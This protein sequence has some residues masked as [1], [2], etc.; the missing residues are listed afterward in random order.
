MKFILILCLVGFGLQ[1]NAQSHRITGRLM[2]QENRPVSYAGVYLFS[3]A[4]SLHKNAVQSD[5]A[6]YFQIT[7]GLKGQYLVKVRYIGYQ[8][9]TS[10]VFEL[11][12]PGSVFSM[13]NIQLKEDSHSLQTVQ[14]SGARPMIEQRMDKMVMNVE[15]SILSKGSTALELLSK[16]PGVTV[17]EGGSVSLKGRPGTQVMINGKLTYLSASQLANLLRGTASDGVAKVELMSNPSSRYD[18]AGK[19]GIINI[20]MKKNVKTGLNGNLSMNGGAGKAAR[21]GTGTDLNYR[22]EK[23]NVFG[24]YNYFYQNLE[25]STHIEREFSRYSIQQTS[26]KGRLRSQNFRAGMDVFLNEKNT[27]GFL[28]NGGVGKYPT[29]QDTRNQMFLGQGL[30]SDSHTLTEGKE[31]WRDMLYNVNYVHKFNDAGHELSVDL[32]Y[33]DHYS[34]MDQQLDTRYLK[35]GTGDLLR[36]S[37]RIGDIPSD[38]KIYVAKMDYTLPVGK[39]GKLEAG[40]K[41]SFVRTENNLTYDTLKNET[42]AHDLTTSNHF[43]YKEEIQAGYVNFKETFGKFSVQVGLRGEHTYT[44]GHQITID[45]LNEQRYFKL[46]PTFFMSRE[47]GENHKMQLGYSRRIERPS[48]WDLNAFRVYTDPFSY[49]EGNPYLKPAI[50]NAFEL[51]YSYRS[52]YHATASYNR[53]QDVIS[54]VVGLQGEQ[55]TFLRPQNMASFVNYGISFT[56]S[57]DLTPWWT[58]TQFLNLFHNEFTIGDQPAAVKFKGNS[59]NFDSQNTFKL[60]NG[61][62]AELNG[63]LRSKETS[64]VFSTKA[65]YMISAGGQKEVLNGRGTINLAINDIF[66]SKKYTQMSNYGGIRTHSFYQPDSRSAVLSFS[67]RFGGELAGARAR[68]TGSEE[69]KS[70]LK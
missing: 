16:L 14:I 36:L 6:G 15:N 57:I 26:E 56:T 59:L 28:I 39:T 50:V 27:L 20:V 44:K 10:G 63:L 42:Y 46:F 60:G 70:R 48:Y 21:F 66:K 25:N 38:N 51:G 54:S 3:S 40:W 41:G 43:K 37:S 45:S 47:M 64:G 18:A 24:S 32:D 5:S 53:T 67:Y 65:Y 30:I 58:G 9:Y 68:N 33:V 31:R 8:S 22:S 12:E 19:G 23:I 34:K 52:K 29:V 1:V 62:K 55:V 35:P 11:N 61:W 49:E 2:D 4:D 7:A 69:L 13:G 17:D